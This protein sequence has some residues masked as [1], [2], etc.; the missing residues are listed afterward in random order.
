M[1]KARKPTVR[2]RSKDGTYP[3]IEAY[4]RKAGGRK[5]LRVRYPQA[6]RKVVQRVTRT[7]RPGSPHPLG[8]TVT[9]EGINFA[10]HSRYAQDLFLVLFD[11][12]DGE[13]T[14]VIPLVARTGFTRHA[15]VSGLGHGQLYAFRA[16]GEFNPAMGLRFNESKLLLDPYARA[17]AGAFQA[18]GNVLLAYDANS[19][20]KDLGLDERDDT[21]AMPKCIAYGKAFDWEGDAPPAIPMAETLI[22]EVHLKGMTANANSGVSA[23]GTYLG[24]IEKIPYLQKLGINAVE[25]LPIHAHY[26]EDH[27]GEKGLANYWGYNTFGFF[28]PEASYGSGRE[29]GCEVEEF[30]SLVKALHK[31]GIEV[32]LDVVYNHTCEGNELG[33]TVSFKG[34]D[35]PSYYSLAGGADH[36]LRYYNN[37]SGTGNTLDFGSPAV[38]RLTL[39]SLRHWVE[40][41]HVDG[42]RFDLA[43]CLGRGYWNGF[44]PRAPFFQAVAQDPVLRSVKL[45]AEPWDCGGYGAGEFPVN[46]VEWNGKFRDNI[47]RLVKGDP[48]QLNELGWRVTGSA[49]LFADG[50]RTSD[51]GVNFVTC[52][53]GFTVADLVSYNEKHNEA[54]GEESRDGSDDNMSWNCGA[55]GETRDP[56]VIE[57][58]RRQVKNFACLLLFSQGVP[59][60]SHGDEMLRTQKGNN[61]AYCQDN[62]LAWMDWDLEKSNADMLHFWRQAIALRKRLP[63]LMGRRFLTGADAD[64]NEVP[65]IAWFAPDGKA[66]DWN[67]GVRLAFQLD[68]YDDA[69]PEGGGPTVRELSRFYFIVNPTHEEAEYHLPPLLENHGWHRLA[70]TSLPA[71]ADFLEPGRS[72]ALAD[73]LIYRAAARSVVILV[74]RMKRK[75]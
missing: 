10:V 3:T 57:L 56:A 47:R 68:G 31:A 59:M 5:G 34:L 44:D 51:A 52:H 15:F 63:L 28:A 32:I 7:V 22:Y 35:N 71:G 69:E 73:P 50:G 60:I 72:V 30:K 13:P 9:P 16:R 62:P 41:Y 39:D 75:A 26:P 4:R 11:R 19:E 14:E 40:E 46:W 74:N 37:W 48:G 24:F 53:D 38:V 54:N 8:A 12:P 36:P 2:R 21:L 64:R 23:P 65:D 1:K 29:P 27:L 61:N 70:D 45:I 33:P 43:L 58:R 42:F 67:D 18:A 17:H 55:E 25:L 49:D 20:A 6:E 66:V